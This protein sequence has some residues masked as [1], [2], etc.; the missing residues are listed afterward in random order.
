MAFL[1]MEIVLSILGVKT[2]A[3]DID[4]LV[5]FSTRF[6][7]FEER[8]TED[9][10]AVFST[11]KNR[12]ELFNAQAFSVEKPE[13]AVRI[14]CLGGSTTYGRPYEDETSFSGFLRNALVVA[15]PNQQWEVINAGGISYASPRISVLMHELVQYQP[16]LFIIYT[17][18]NEFL[19]DRTYSSLIDMPETVQQLN[20]LASHSRAVSVIHRLIHHSVQKVPEQNEF[21]DVETKLDR[22]VGPSVYHRDEAWHTEVTQQFKSN[23]ERIIFAAQS[24]NCPVIL[25]TPA[26]KQRD[27][28]PFKSEHRSGMTPE[29]LREF[30]SHFENSNAAFV[31]AELGQA[32]I[33]IQAALNL[34][35]QFA[36][37]QFLYG[38]IL[39]AMKE[40]EKAKEAFQ[41]AIEEDICPLR[42]NQELI[43]I[44]R[45]VAIAHQ[46]PFIDYVKL[47]EDQSENSI[48]G[49]DWFLDHVHP[50]IG[51]HRLLA[52]EMLEEIFTL[53]IAHPGNDWSS[54]Q[55]DRVANGVEASIDSQKHAIA[56]RNLAKVLSWA[57]KQRE[58]DRL[59]QQ[60][61]E[62]LPDDAETHCMAG[63]AAISNDSLAQAQSHFEESLQLDPGN[64]RSLSGLGTVFS[65]R[66]EFETSQKLL[67]KAVSLDPK[68]VPAWFNLGNAFLEQGKHTQAIAAYLRALELEPNHPDA[69]KNLGLTYLA[70]GNLEMAVKR[71]ETATHLEPN[72]AQRHADLGFILVDAGD[73]PRSAKEFETALKLNPQ[74]IP[75]LIGKGLVLEQ[76][77]NSAAAIKIWEK[78]LLIDPENQN[79]QDLIKRQR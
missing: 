36:H 20:G 23:L 54:E 79:A 72:S 73:L 52:K 61:I 30:E 3:S 57:G 74:H 39:Y 41:N 26:S 47:V 1:L 53:K 5:G 32:L 28:E 69:E 63:F 49:E 21:E 70:V 14:F 68:Q 48:P 4:P 16:D 11:A 59:A 71:F 15:D 62:L 27:C 2:I 9:G 6:P 25:V 12:L 58:A 8:Q 17:G 31:N 37:A 10:I 65:Q 40:F 51:G 67:E 56:L 77:G 13:N 78:I 46:L 35:E 24:V 50:T 75:G 76:S 44:V 7:L 19:E 42:A 60:A 38:E 45:E 66:G 55:F 64:V 43:S 33:E 29:E 34:D 22:A 18:H